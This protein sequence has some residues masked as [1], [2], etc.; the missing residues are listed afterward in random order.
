MKRASFAL[1]L[2]VLS[3]CSSGAPP[4]AGCG[5]ALGCAGG[6]CVEL[7]Y[8]ALDG[9]EG[10][11][12]FCTALCV[13]DADCTALDGATDAACVTLD[14]DAPLRYL[15]A[16]RCTEPSDCYAG[17]RCTETN[18]VSVGSVCLP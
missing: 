17:L 18:D 2:G 7:L 1:F 9:S 6:D 11:G 8:T 4:Y 15:C 13:S 12:T 3:G 14:R 10:G 16:A 5:G